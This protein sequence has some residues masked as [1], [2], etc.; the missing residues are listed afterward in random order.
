MEEACRAEEAHIQEQHRQAEEAF[1]V[2]E[3]VGLAFQEVLLP[4]V[5]EGVVPFP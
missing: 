1:Q 4:S 2:E 3:E 5:Q